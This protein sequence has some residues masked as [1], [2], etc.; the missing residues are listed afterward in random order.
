MD[1]P[2]SSIDVDTEKVLLSNAL[3]AWEGRTLFTIAHRRETLRS[4]DRIF[5]LERGRIS[6]VCLPSELLGDVKEFL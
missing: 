6:R 3:E 2:T 4:F 5:V 1:E